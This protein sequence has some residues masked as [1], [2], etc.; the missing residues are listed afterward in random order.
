[1]GKT[2]EVLALVVADLHRGHEEG[3]GS[4]PGA[5]KTKKAKKG[6][7]GAA[8]EQVVGCGS[9][10]PSHRATLVVCPASV[11]ANWREQAEMHIAS[12]SALRVLVHHGKTKA[13]V[14]GLLQY[15]LVL[16]SYGTLSAEVGGGGAGDGAESGAAQSAKRKRD[17]G[18]VAAVLSKFE[19]HRVVLD[20][21]HTIRYTSLLVSGLGF[22]VSGLR[23]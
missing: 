12:S 3:S 8:K 15:D 7:A 17:A 19:W 2:L 22:R 16:T 5:A 4:R 10:A 11:L 9:S 20:E 23:V 13:T 18:G 21:A 1:L 14:A 6:G